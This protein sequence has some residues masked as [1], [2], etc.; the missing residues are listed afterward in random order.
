MKQSLEST[1]DTFVRTMRCSGMVHSLENDDLTV[2][3]P[4]KKRRLNACAMKEAEVAVVSVEQE[5]KNESEKIDGD[6]NIDVNIDVNMNVNGDGA[7]EQENKNELEKID[8]DVN[9]NVNGDGAVEQENK[10]E[11]EKIDGDVNMNVN[12]DGA[13]EQEKIELCIQQFMKANKALQQVLHESYN[14]CE[15][16]INN[17]E[18]ANTP[19]FKTLIIQN[20]SKITQALQSFRESVQNVRDNM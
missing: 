17:E 18:S 9:M 2:F 19:Q 12:G 7:V 5:N 4:N 1:P 10:N 6:V 13:V 8:G 14:H 20:D 3:P 15:Q 11:L 16:F